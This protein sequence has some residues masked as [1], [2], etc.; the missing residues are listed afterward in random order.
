MDLERADV[1]EEEGEEMEEVVIC[2]STIAMVTINSFL[3]LADHS[4]TA[5]EPSILGIRVPQDRNLNATR[6]RIIGC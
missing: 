5:W 3:A 6:I 4:C 1:P 2:M